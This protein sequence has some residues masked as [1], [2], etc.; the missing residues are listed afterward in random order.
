M[1]RMMRNVLGLSRIDNPDERRISSIMVIFSIVIFVAILPPLIMDLIAEWYESVIALSAECLVILAVLLL[2]RKRKTAAAGNLLLF[3]LLIVVSYVMYEGWGI[4]GVGVFCFP[5]FLIVGGLILS[6]TSYIVLTVTCM[7]SLGLMSYLEA[8]QLVTTRFS[9]IALDRIHYDYVVI[10]IVTAFGVSLIS[11]HF[12]DNVRRL[13]EQQSVLM[14]RKEKSAEQARQVELSEALW[15]SL[16]YNSPDTIMQLKPEGSIEF[17]NHDNSGFQAAERESIL[18]LVKPDRKEVFKQALQYTSQIQTPTEHELQLG[19]AERWYAVRVIPF[20]D[21]QEVS[22]LLLATDVTDHKQNEMNRK[23]LEQKMQQAQ[24]LD[25][26]STLATG[27]AHDFNNILAIITAYAS[28]I[29]TEFSMHESESLNAIVAASEKAAGIVRQMS[30]F[31]LEQDVDFRAI[32]MVAFVEELVRELQLTMPPDLIMRF[33]STTES[34]YVAGDVQK[35]HQALLNLC[36]NARDAMDGQGVLRLSLDTLD[37]TQ[38]QAE[39]CNR[40]C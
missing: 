12:K 7:L 34:I 31:T 14:D 6:R 11:K 28:S 16:V 32:D 23:K 27:I 1:I 22:L 15:S 20:K 5:G 24:R 37:S 35:V 9:H 30:T 21:H 26:I 19:E 33:E 40:R 39:F 17:V 36:L 8:N 4:R 13:R 10:L 18:D 38:V 3:S 25:S 2:I 29:R